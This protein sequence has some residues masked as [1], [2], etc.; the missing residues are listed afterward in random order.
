MN[1]HNTENAVLKRHVF[2]EAT[3]GY[4]ECLCGWP[5]REQYDAG[6]HEVLHVIAELCESGVLTRVIPPEST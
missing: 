1:A 5:T 6:E 2:G 4:I 3:G